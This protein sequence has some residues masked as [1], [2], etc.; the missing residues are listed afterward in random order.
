MS[1]ALGIPAHEIDAWGS[2][3]L[4]RYVDFA[5]RH[6]LPQ[7]RFEQYLAQIPFYTVAASGYGSKFKFKDFMIGRH[8]DD[9]T[10]EH[11]EEVADEI[12]DNSEQAQELNAILQA[13]LSRQNRGKKAQEAKNEV[14]E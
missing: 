13:A 4:M 8:S 6:G 5:N 10:Q 12:E 1:F 7:H 11:Q 9:D 3:K 2:D 14:T